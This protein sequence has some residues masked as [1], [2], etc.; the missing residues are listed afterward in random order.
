MSFHF[1]FC[2]VSSTYLFIE[3]HCACMQELHVD[4]SQFPLWQ[5][6]DCREALR[7]LAIHKIPR[8]C[9]GDGAVHASG[10]FTVQT[11][12]GRRDCETHDL[13]ARQLIALSHSSECSKCVP[14]HA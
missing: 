2:G 1:Y 9:S 14:F 10:T 12:L 11:L 13:L 3:L 5:V 4:W 8:L 6:V 7:S